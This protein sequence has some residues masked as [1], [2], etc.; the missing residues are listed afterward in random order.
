MSST[1]LV[2]QLGDGSFQ[3]LDSAVG[4][5]E[6]ASGDLVALKAVAAEHST[7]AM[8]AAAE[9][10]SLTLCPFEAS[11]AKLLRQTLPYELE[12]GLL[13]DVDTLHFSLGEPV[14]GTVPVAVIG[15]EQMQGWQTS[16][17]EQGLV[18]HKV[19][20]EITLLPWLDKQWTLL[21]DEQRWL[22]RHAE[23]EGFALEA[24]LAI[25]AMTLLIEEQGSP[26]SLVLY[27]SSAERE[28]VK[29]LLPESLQ[30]VVVWQES[31]YWP[32]ISGVKNE[33]EPFSLLQG[34]FARSLPWGK[35]W[36]QWRITAILLGVVI[37]LQLAMNVVELQALKS[38]NLQL[39]A[40]IE[41]SYR[42]AIPKGAVVN[43]EKQLRRK[44]NA[45]K[46]GDGGSFVSLLNKVA[47]V[48]ASVKDFT[49]LNMSY[50]EKQ[51]EI[52]LTVLAGSF[53]DVE[54]VRSGLEQQG[55]K[56][57]L[58]GSSNENGKTR[59]RLRIRG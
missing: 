52:R 59:A 30:S 23:F 36:Q 21:I 14:E 20:P 12:E 43:P 51:S 35:W 33:A 19:L 57:E 3:W 13:Q 31:S 22:L 46:G 8:L 41:R 50:S 28:P 16:F 49:L 45:M 32:I 1:I 10:C 25:L 48:S 55:L 39:R 34:H 47:K 17:Q 56:A 18:L 24:E 29:E 9:C 11:E 42:S 38:K 5:G 37:G 4:I 58:T 2:R 7:I 6:V 44:V 27:C 15:Q 54:N 40:D 26:D 53:N